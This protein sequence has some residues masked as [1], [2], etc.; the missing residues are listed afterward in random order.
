MP[1]IRPT[2]GEKVLCTCCGEFKNK[3]NFYTSKSPKNT[4]G[5]AYVCK[6]CTKKKLQDYR[7]TETGFWVGMWNNIVGGAKDR[8]LELSITKE[9]LQAIWISQKGLCAVTGIPMEKIRATKTTRN[10]YKNLYK[11]SLDRIDSELGYT[12]ENVRMVCAHVNVMKMDLTD[13][14]L[15]FWCS[16]VLKGVKENG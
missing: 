15:I 14:Q 1:K 12:K 2:Q 13:E 11:A 4:L 6:V 16:A 7:N 3:H 8:G 9:D 5:L 10:R